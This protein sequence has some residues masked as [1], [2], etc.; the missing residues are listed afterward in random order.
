ME[1]GSLRRTQF[2]EVLEGM[3]ATPSKARVCGRRCFVQEGPGRVCVCVCVSP[4][5]CCC[6]WFFINGIPGW[7]EGVDGKLVMLMMRICL[8]SLPAACPAR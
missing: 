6:Y 2:G 8:H 4:Q 5:I 1:H 7:Q 3:E